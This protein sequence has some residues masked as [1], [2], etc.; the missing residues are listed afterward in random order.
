MHGDLGRTS[1]SVGLLLNCKADILQLD[2]TDVEDRWSSLEA[3][4]E[5]GAQATAVCALGATDRAHDAESTASGAVK[6]GLVAVIAAVVAEDGLRV[7]G[8]GGT[9]GEALAPSLL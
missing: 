8:E 6:E 1:P 9:E 2:V 5:R 4:E 3:E 7:G